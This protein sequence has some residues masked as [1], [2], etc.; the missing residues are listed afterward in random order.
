MSSLYE[1]TRLLDEYLLFH[2]GSTAEIMPWPFGPV[3]ALQ[4]PVRTVSTFLDASPRDRALDLGCAVGRSAF[5][6]SR[7]CR[8]VMG[9][10]YSRNFI[11]AAEALRT[12]GR[13]H[14]NC[15]EEAASVRPLIASRPAGSCPERLSFEQGDAM[16]L[17]EDIG[18]FDLVHAANLLCRLTDPG[19]LLNRLPALV[20]P[21]GLLILTTPCTWLEE[22]TPPDRWP[23]HNTFEWLQDAISPHFILQQRADLPFLIREHARKF[24]WSVA[25]GTA[26]LRKTSF[27]G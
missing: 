24:Q 16:Q 26:W 10:D 4:F 23:P 13:L 8:E 27:G 14:Y 21:G 2:Y 17:R 1:S 9:I 19:L 6:L 15:R 12:E 11:A 3:E 25:L 22:F 7:T 5:E 18:D 20:R